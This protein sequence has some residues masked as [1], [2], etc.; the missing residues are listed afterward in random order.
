MKERSSSLP[1]VSFIVPVHNDAVRLERCLR[2]IRMSWYSPARLEIIVADNG[3]QDDSVAVA[4]RWG[5]EV[6]VLP[7]APVAELRNRAAER[8]TGDILAC[9]DADHELVSGWIVSAVET[10]QLPGVAAVGALYH[11]PPD[12]TWVQR[13]YGYLRGRP[14]GRH[15]VEWIASGN[16]A[17]WRTAFEAVGGFDTSLETCEDVDL[18]HRLRAAGFRV[19]SDERLGNIHYGDPATLWELFTSEL[20]RGR[21]NLRVSFR[22][23]RTW[24]ILASAIIP[25]LDVAL[26]AI[27]LLGLLMAT[28]GGLW[29]TLPAVVALALSAWLKVARAAFRH[30]RSSVAGVVQ[31]FAVACVYNMGRALALISRTPHRG[32]RSATT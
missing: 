2:S 1:R 18:C 9:V 13:A 31:A 22:P 10:L 14:S 29:V 26:I 12:G 24:R 20:W 3:S 6:L 17:V 27:G 8:A 30:P 4:K 32:G 23:P 19:L 15:D 7:F 25:M 16:L 5:A 21:D 28:R 11:A